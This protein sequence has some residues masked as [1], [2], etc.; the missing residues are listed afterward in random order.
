M[1]IDTRDLRRHVRAHAELAAREV[2]G[3]L[4]GLQRQV[5][6][7]DAE[8]GVEMLDERRHH[9][10]VATRHVVIDECA[11]QPVEPRRF[12][13]QQILDAGGQ[14]PEVVHGNPDSGGRDVGRALEGPHTAPPAE[15]E[16]PVGPVESK[17][18]S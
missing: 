6:A 4:E 12:G 11:A 3:E 2:I 15:P 18:M 10:I 8:K 16:A 13:R 1:S 5:L 7:A 17:T 14:Q 9:E